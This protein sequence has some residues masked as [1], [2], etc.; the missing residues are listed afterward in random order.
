MHDLKANGSESDTKI[1]LSRRLNEK[2]NMIVDL[3]EENDLQ[4]AKY[5]Y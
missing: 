3:T 1:V 5:V 2:G 4:R